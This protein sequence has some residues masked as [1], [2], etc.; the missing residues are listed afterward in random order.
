[1]TYDAVDHI[2]WA[3]DVIGHAGA[4]K[5]HQRL[6]REVYGISQ[7]DVEALLPGCKICVVNRTNNTK[8]PLEP[9]VAIRVLERVQID[10]IDFRHQPDG[11]FKW[12]MHI[13]FFI[14]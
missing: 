12:I 6:M 8:P 9:I 11:R 7:D 5:T 13:L 1:M 14:S 3:H 2:A 10:L 4:R